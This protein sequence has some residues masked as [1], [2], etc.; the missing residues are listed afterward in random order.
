MGEPG[1]L[2][3]DSRESMQRI[4]ENEYYVAD[5]DH[6]NLR[7]E[8]IRS[9]EPFADVSAVLR[10]L[11][12]F[13]AAVK[14]AGADK[15]GLLL[16]ST[17]AP[18]ARGSGYQKAFARLADF[19]NERFERIAVVVSS[20]EAALEELSTAPRSHVDFFT[21]RPAARNALSIPPPR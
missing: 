18:H 2:K 16:D 13:M 17:L 8:M 7:I 19:L 10:T 11:D 15:Y 3:T 6:E 5:V 20:R 4:F 9:S 12:H 21:N 1:I 14:A